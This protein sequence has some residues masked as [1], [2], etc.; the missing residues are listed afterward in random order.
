MEANTMKAIVAIG[1]GSPE[2]LKL[3][4]VIIPQPKEN[5]VLVRVHASSATTADQMMRTGQPYFGRLFT[6]LQKPKHPTPG[7]G[8]AGEIISV[9]TKVVAFKP[10]E[11]VLGETTLGFSTNAEFVTVPENGVILPMPKNMSYTE[12]APICDGALTS[13]NF[14]RKVTKLQAG[15]KILINGA[16]G[17]LG[18]AAI[19]LAKYFGAEVT[20]VCGSK[21]LKLIK[22][23]GADHVI[24]YTNGPIFHG[25]AKYDIIFDTVGKLNYRNV[26]KSLSKNGFYLS[27]VLEFPLLID[28]FKTSLFS[29]KRAKFA[30]T[31]MK[32]DKSLRVMLAELLNIHEK[33]HLKIVVDRL[34]PLEELANAHH[35]ISKGHKKGN[36]VITSA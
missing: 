19:Q 22:S 29:K 16:S 14:L 17:S 33:G 3:K 20:G 13:L 32:S 34:Y 25:K 35:Y 36:V 7:T 26:K 4:E 21:N 9:G 11:R 24:D 30:A 15:Q 1:Y 23:L 2:V 6:G 27:P 12:A 8:F 28:M 31:G 10:G 18:T 5:E